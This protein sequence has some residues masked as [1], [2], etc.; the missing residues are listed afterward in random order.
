[1]G[2]FDNVVVLDE[3]LRCPHGHRVE[4]FQ[5]KSFDDP[6]M[7][8][9]LF[10]GPRVSR[11]VRGRFADPGE[12][13]ATH[14]QLDGKEA[15][16]QRRHGVEPILPPRE[17]VFY[18]SCGECT[19]VLIR[20]DRARAWGDLVDERQLWVEFRATFGPGEPRRIERT[21]G[22]RDD[23]VTELRE[24]GLR[25]LRDREPLAIAHHEIRAARDEAPSRR[26]R[27]RC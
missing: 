19:P 17:I 23:L 4:G 7:N 12:T 16:F 13:A 24:E 6:S 22:T 14:W 26:R 10:E 9:Y 11:V 1:M 5:T 27:R 8:T 3:T 15:V 2:M 20:C 18:T 21:S 25:V